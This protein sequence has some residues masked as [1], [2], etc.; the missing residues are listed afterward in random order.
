MIPAASRSKAAPAQ[1]GLFLVP[2]A[3]TSHSLTTPLAMATRL[4]SVLMTPNVLLSSDSGWFFDLTSATIQLSKTLNKRLVP[5]PPRTRPRKSSGIG[6][7]G[8]VV[9]MQD[10]A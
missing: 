10:V 1:K 7:L 6:P 8:R 5:M 9:R 3:V 2:V 4:L